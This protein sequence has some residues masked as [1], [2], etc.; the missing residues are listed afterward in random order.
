MKEIILPII[1]FGTKYCIVE[2]PF[3]MVQSYE[4]EY[5]RVPSRIKISGEVT[6]FNAN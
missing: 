3:T 1:S 5:G 6:I 2:I 4:K